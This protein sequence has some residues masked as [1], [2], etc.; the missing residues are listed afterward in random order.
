MS[1]IKLYHGTNASN[2]NNVIDF[3]KATK[4]INGF[5][6]YATRDIGVA[7]LYGS[8]VVCWE[9]EDTFMDEYITLERPIDQRYTA[10]LATYE[11]CVAGGMEVYMPSNAAIHMA[12]ECLD[13]YEV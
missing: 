13:A 7:R 4:N 1:I 10:G 5:G 9:V 2:T 8:K 11:E 6:F 12:D 3:P